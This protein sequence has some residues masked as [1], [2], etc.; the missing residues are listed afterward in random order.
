MS[1]WLFDDYDVFPDEVK[2]TVELTNT[3]ITVV[4]VSGAEF[5]WYMYNI[6]RH[7]DIDDTA[8]LLRE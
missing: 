2:N 3:T 7:I 8:S 4:E 6:Y 5:H 1:D